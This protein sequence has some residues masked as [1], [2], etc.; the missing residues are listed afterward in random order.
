MA[1]YDSNSGDKTHPVGRKQANGLGLYDMSGNVWEWVND[2]Y[3]SGYYGKSPRNNPQGRITGAS[4][5]SRGG[6]WRN[7]PARVRASHRD[8]CGTGNRYN[9][10]GFRLVAPVQ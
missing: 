8:D 3:D 10:V 7:A 4:R 6:S 1:W 2:W 9:S 5:I